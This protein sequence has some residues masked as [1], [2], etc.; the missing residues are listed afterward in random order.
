MNRTLSR[1]PSQLGDTFRIYY[2]DPV[3]WRSQAGMAP[4]VAPYTPPGTADRLGS[5][6]QAMAELGMDTSWIAPA[7]D[8][9]GQV[10]AASVAAA[11][12]AERQKKEEAAAKKKKKKK[13]KASKS[14]TAKKAKADEED[15]HEP[16][17][18]DPSGLPWGPILA[19]GAAL[20]IGGVLLLR[21]QPA[22][23]GGYAPAPSKKE[24]A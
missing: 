2:A 13:K 16:P 5:L 4:S 1:Q 15:E 6:G 7:I 24:I 18:E 17:P 14:S 3:R 19:G 9:A 21:K 23:A 8:A 20:L 10:T 22:S 12:E 11:N